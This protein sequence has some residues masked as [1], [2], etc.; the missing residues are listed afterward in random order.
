MICLF[1][2]R[3]L[4]V[5]REG[6]NRMATKSPLPSQSGGVHIEGGTVSVGGDIVG[7]DKVVNSRELKDVLRPL[8]EAISTAPPENRADAEAKLEELTREIAKGEKGGDGIVADALDRLVGLVPDAADA[9]ISAFG[10][11]ILGAI[12]GPVT[13]F[14]LGKIRHK[15]TEP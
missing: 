5:V 14:V 7:R 13:K 4:V 6:G 11:P 2:H 3:F 10:S 15:Y 1:G 8:A 9:A 12:A